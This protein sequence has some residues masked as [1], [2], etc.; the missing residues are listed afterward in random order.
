MS[1]ALAALPALLRALRQAGIDVDA[2][3]ALDAA[4]LALRMQRDPHSAKDAP[5]V[6]TGHG[7]PRPSGAR[8]S[9]VVDREGL[10]AAMTIDGESLPVRSSGPRRT[11]ESTE[12]APARSLT[13]ER[14]SSLPDRRDLIKALRP[15]RRR[16]PSP[17]SGVV[18]IDATVRRAAEEDLWIPSFQ[19]TRERWLD[20]L[21]V[22][23][24]GLSMILWKETLDEFERTLR[25]SGAFRSVRSWWLDTDTPEP[26][27]RARGRGQSPTSPA[28]LAHL[29]RG[30]GRSVML[31]VSDCVGARWHDGAIPKLMSQWSSALPLALV[32]VTPEWFWART[33]LGDT[34][35]TRLRSASPATVNR[36]MRW[37]S[38]AL[39]L[40]GASPETTD[41]LLRV[42]AA[43]MTPSG[44]ARI[45]E[46]I[47]GVGR[48]WAPGVVF[49]LA[50]EGE[51]ENA[52]GDDDAGRAARFLTLASKDAKRLA[53]AL[54]AS[55]VLTLGVLRLLRRDLLPHAT[56]FIEAEVLLGGIVRVR[57][58]E[59]RWDAGASL[60]L[61]FIPGVRSRLLDG[62]LAGD[63][64]RVLT[65][66][67]SVA[68]S[69]VGP[70]FTAWLA[71]PSP[72]AAQLDPEES[73][74]AAAAADVLRRLGG[75]YARIVKPS[76]SDDD[77]LTMEFIVSGR[78]A[79][80]GFRTFVV[81]VADEIGV[82]GTA[83]NRRD[84]TIEV[85]AEGT[86]RGLDQL[87][88]KLRQGPP[89]A[90]I[91]HL[92]S[93]VLTSSRPATEGSTPTA[94]DA[95]Q[96]KLHAWELDF[97]QHG[98]IEGAGASSV[99]AAVHIAGVTDLI[100]LIHGWNVDRAAGRE[101]YRVFL[102]NVGRCLAGGDGGD[103]RFGGL[104]VFWP[105][106]RWADDED[107]PGERGAFEPTMAD[108]ERLATATSAVQANADDPNALARLNE[109]LQELAV[110]SAPRE[111]AV[112]AVPKKSSGL[113]GSLWQSAKDLLRSATYYQMRNRAGDIGRAGLGPFLGQL[114]IVQPG[115]RVHIVAH[116]IG[117][118]LA[119]HALVAN[120]EDYANTPPIVK[121]VSLLQAMISSHAFAAE[122]PLAQAMRVRVD[123]P[124][125]VTFSRNDKAA[126]TYPVLARMAAGDD[127]APEGER[128]LRAMAS[129]GDRSSSAIRLELA[130]VGSEY[131]IRGGS[132][133]NVDA[134]RVVLS[135]NDVYGPEI[136]WLVIAAARASSGLSH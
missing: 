106:Q 100:V 81:R 82:T 34:V 91:E 37:D 123:G 115:V 2:E 76:T 80:V 122:L 29:T 124:V 41:G 45:A 64:V 15:L 40:M 126:A 5:I 136:A 54:A 112:K 98:G 107:G 120:L 55:P 6:T 75:G 113:F 19:P 8:S 134:T 53:A 47:A 128:E 39:G 31:V 57:R 104:G 92:D 10:L 67:A 32:Q 89:G 36:G 135:H 11:D 83:T 58:D 46:L 111:L 85:R 99:G 77:I 102:D 95:P 4:W 3:S 23:D 49:D 94:A 133:Y 69:G 13:L 119:T 63:V 78:V 51:A 21:L 65:H 18:D 93:R 84:G 48:E 38:S 28:K 90:I 26:R 114:G 108:R 130:P 129:D 27:V 121:S 109:L 20:V 35:E 101:P 87:E 88:A 61:E 118:R 103:R 56:P 7:S 33:A 74:F 17:G 116:S 52:Q 59:A 43:T 16:V 125:I 68:G 105:S 25:N 30:A 22:A 1:D 132:T 60:P 24:H 71:D 12:S 14:A 131:G 62:A 44:L 42:P 50:W 9:G 66:A 73:P 96:T 110:P 86:R 70:T 72:G 117:A 127:D 97:D 79:G